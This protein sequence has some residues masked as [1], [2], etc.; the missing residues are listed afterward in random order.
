MPQV[1]AEAV[2]VAVGQR[3]RPAHHLA[4]RRLAQAVGIGGALDLDD[5]GAEVGEQPAQFA[6]C[7]DHAEVEDPQSVERP[8]RPCRPTGDGRNAAVAQ[9]VS[10]GT[11]RLAR[12]V[13]YPAWRPSTTNGPTGTD[14]S[15]ARGEIDVGQCADG[16]EM[17]RR[18]RSARA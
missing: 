10:S 4:R 7:D 17:L 9:A 5:L 11:E 1:Q 6:A 15:G 12:G 16:T 8:A 18:Q 13:A 2:L 3:P 14:T